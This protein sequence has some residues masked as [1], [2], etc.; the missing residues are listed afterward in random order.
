[1]GALRRPFSERAGVRCRKYSR[2]LQ[3]AITDFGVE[4]SFARA[5]GRL[6]EHYGIKVPVSAI[7]DITEAHALAAAQFAV[8]HPPE[9]PHPAQ[10]LIAELDGSMVPI[11]HIDPEN[12]PPTSDRRKRRKVEW[13]E[14]RLCVVQVQGHVDAH[15]GVSFGSTAEA[16]L[17]LF[18]TA[19][20][21][22]Y[23]GRTSVHGLGDGAPWICEQF[24]QQFGA[25][26][27]YLLDL[28]H[29]CDY[30][31]AAG[32]DLSSQ[33]ALWLKN[34]KTLL[35]ANRWPQVLGE[36]SAHLEPETVADDQAPVRCAHRYLSNRTNQ[37]D[38]AGAIAQ[39][40]PIGSGMVE[41]AHRH[42]LQQRLKISGAWW[43][44]ENASA[45]AHLRVLRAN[46]RWPAYW[47]SHSARA[48]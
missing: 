18:R 30:L 21:A 31:S 20:Q 17:A 37:L 19:E 7:R 32:Q 47:Q 2:P 25:N 11:V 6:Q 9:K 35:Q 36:L 5:A 29:L 4:E 10:Q 40:L 13:K 42:I 38:Y 39:E 33:P 34:Q 24:E 41:S 26:A 28:Y 45:I 48:A 23:G 16:G 15:Y 43:S 8:Q 3:R 1:M 44:Y 27:R 22:G 46:Q 12:A 14:A